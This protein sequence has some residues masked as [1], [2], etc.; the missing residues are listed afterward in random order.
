MKKTILTFAILTVGFF[1][2]L[3]A[4]GYEY[5]N[6]YTRSNGTYVQGYYRSRPDGC[7]YNNM[8]YSGNIN[9]FTGKTGSSWR[10]CGNSDKEGQECEDEAI[11]DKNCE[12]D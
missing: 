2:N 6:S 3:N 4:Q 8:S 9:P 11:A 10:Q 7:S 1:G 12:V 5:V